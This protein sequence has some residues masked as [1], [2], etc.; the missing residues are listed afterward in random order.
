M[1]AAAAAV[2]F[3]LLWFAVL[4]TGAD[5]LS[6]ASSGPGA[7]QPLSDS[8]C[9][10]EGSASAEDNTTSIC[11]L[12]SDAQKWL[13]LCGWTLNHDGDIHIEDDTDLHSWTYSI[14][15]F[16]SGRMIIGK[17]VNMQT[18]GPGKNIR[19]HASELQIAANVAI[20]AGTETFGQVELGGSGCSSLSINE[21]AKEV[22]IDAAGISITCADGRV[23]LLGAGTKFICRHYGFVAYANDLLIPREVATITAPQHM[24][25][26]TRMAVLAMAVTHP[27]AE[28]LPAFFLRSGGN[29]GLG[30]EGGQ[31]T[32]SKLDVVAEGIVTVEAG[33]MLH[34]QT[35]HSCLNKA[36][37]N[38]N[39]CGDYTDV[40]GREDWVLDAQVVSKGDIQLLQGSRILAASIA[41]CARKTLK[42]AKR[43]WIGAT[44]RGCAPG[45]GP[46]PGETRSSS[47]GCGAGGGSSLGQGG[48]GGNRVSKECAGPGADRGHVSTAILPTEGAS[49][50]GCG[51]S[52]DSCR[53]VRTKFPTVS[54]GGGMVAFAAQT[55][56]FEEGVQVHADGTGGSRVDYDT[57]VIWRQHE[58]GVSGGGAGGQV[59]MKAEVLNVAPKVLLSA[60][61]GNSDCN[62]Q[63]Y[64]ISGAGGGGFVGIQWDTTEDFKAVENNLQINVDG[65]S[66][67]NHCRG[68]YLDSREA[69][70][71]KE[72]LAASLGACKD[73]HAGALCL[74]CPVGT[75]S[76]QDW[77]TC[78]ACENK[79]GA[80]STYSGL[81]GWPNASCP[82]QCGSGIP[83]VKENP[84][85]VCP[86]GRG[87]P[88]CEPCPAGWWSN[89]SEELTGCYRC[90]PKPGGRNS[91]WTHTQWPNSTCP[92]SCASG[93]PSKELPYHVCRWFVHGQ[94]CTGSAWS[95]DEIPPSIDVLR[96]HG[97]DVDSAAWQR[98]AADLNAA[99]V[100]PHSEAVIMRILQAVF[101]PAAPLFAYWRRKARARRVWQ[102]CFAA[103]DTATGE[104]SLW[105]HEPRIPSNV[106]NAPSD[107]AFWFGCDAAATVGFIDFFDYTRNLYDWK[108]VDLGEEARVIIARGHGTYIEPFALEVGDPLVEQIAQAEYG[109]TAVYNVVF[110]FNRVA[111]CLS[112]QQL[113]ESCAHVRPQGHCLDRFQQAMKGEVPFQ[114]LQQVVEECATA[115]G[116]KDIVR[117]VLLQHAYEPP[118]LGAASP[119]QAAP[120]D[121]PNA[122]DSFSDLVRQ[123]ATAG[124]G[125]AGSA[126]PTT[127]E[128]VDVRLGLAFARL[129]PP[130]PGLDR[131]DMLD[132]S[133]AGF[134]TGETILNRCRLETSS[135]GM[136]SERSFI[137]SRHLVSPLSHESLVTL[138][139]GQEVRLTHTRTAKSASRA[140]EMMRQLSVLYFEV[141]GWLSI[142]PVVV[143]CILV[144]LMVI[145]LLETILIASTMA[146]GE[147]W[148]GLAM[149]CLIFPLAPVISSF[150]GFLFVL[151][152]EPRLGRVSATAVLCCFVNF[153]MGCCA[154]R[155]W[156]WLMRVIVEQLL[157]YGALNMH[158]EILEV[159]RDK[160]A[161]YQQ[162]DLRHSSFV[163]D[164]FGSRRSDRRGAGH[165][166]DVM[167][168]RRVSRFAAHTVEMS[169]VSAFQSSQPCTS[170]AASEVAESRIP[171]H[172]GSMDSAHSDGHAKASSEASPF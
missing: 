14:Q 119:A 91:V 46:Q 38:D 22:L 29:V 39:W 120:R 64:E 45:S 63:N 121:A 12:K 1:V 122:T 13:S 134:S 34:M 65:G 87:G 145:H 123:T 72:G 10:C 162:I 26:V 76:N 83:D 23:T 114:A 77:T 40:M 129:L 48:F 166:A 66:M 146:K 140:V 133:M 115:H 19:L 105:Q 159:Q 89:V 75:W 53:H 21:D 168:G 150:S 167:R 4:L 161:T 7:S 137:G 57:G 172:I 24:Y 37:V 100:V 16:A 156:L 163:D 108:P 55:V 109:T 160:E 165:L 15:L 112:S 68:I 131:S 59:L 113:A 78:R 130:G 148:I 5:G 101:A 32:L 142:P 126:T 2:C 73:G 132:I 71:G 52:E 98:L 164:M 149:W 43:A 79:E 128:A 158:I 155:T 92:Y 27:S 104:N 102:L 35:H 106:V 88:D 36:T 103:S 61:G 93:I 110:A 144:F 127:T 151:L 18:V 118:Q 124:E 20:I 153:T 67:P 125:S 154:L 50:G 9:S 42:L 54:R 41:I 47:S 33:H 116:L 135:S 138:A 51:L 84:S 3:R 62:S 107:F 25:H 70:E 169:G 85:C 95:V 82:Y 49:G 136:T 143:V 44:G 152:E 90:D 81:G 74:P 30:Y 6:A 97:M 147:N 117:V 99:A 94:N 28:A 171:S 56:D 31:W 139:S 60:K 157:L 58:N 69:V 141:L 111:R 170:F 11:T 80:S 8:A 17:G 86:A 96:R